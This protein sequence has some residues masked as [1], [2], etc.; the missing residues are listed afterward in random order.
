MINKNKFQE[1]NGRRIYQFYLDEET[2]EITD[3]TSRD[4]LIQVVKCK[5]CAYNDDHLCAWHNGYGYKWF[6]VDDDYCSC[7]KE[8]DECD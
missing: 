4:D 3:I 8:K 2:G 5:D 6:V 1:L 7:G